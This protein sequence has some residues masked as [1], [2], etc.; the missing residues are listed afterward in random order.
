MPVLASSYDEY[1][2]QD[3]ADKLIL[4]YLTHEYGF[5][6]ASSLDY[7]AQHGTR[8]SEDMTGRYD[9]LYLSGG[10]PYAIVEAKRYS[11]ELRDA[12][13]EQARAY[14]TGP[15]FDRP[16]P[17]LII[18]NGRNHLFYKRTETLDPSDGKLR[19]EQIPPTRWIKITSESPG[20]IR[21]LL[22][23]D[24]LLSIL[25]DVYD[26]TFQDISRLFIDPVTGKY[27]RH[28]NPKLR[29]KEILEE[30]QKFVGELGASEQTHIRHAIRAVSLHFTIKILFIKLIEDLSSGSDTPRIIHTLFPRVEYNLIGGLFGYKVLNALESNDRKTA[31]RIFAKS[32][33]FY[34]LLAQDLA[35][36]SWQ[37]IFRFGFNV[38]SVQYGKLFK[39]HNYD[40]F[41]P[42]ES[43]LANIRARLIMIDIRS[44][45]IY[46]EAAQRV[47]V[48]GQLYERLIDEELRNSIG[49]VYTPDITVRF[50]LDLA[51]R[52]LIRLRGSKILEPS[53]GSGHFYRHIYREYV[54]EV[55]AQNDSLGIARDSHAAHM[56]ALGHIY[57]RDIDPFAI[58]LTLLGVFLEQLKDNVPPATGRGKHPWA[59]NQSV[60]TQNS[61]DPITIDP[62]RYFD[63]QERTLDLSDAK[64]RQR[65]CRR[66]LSPRLIIGNPP[67]GVSVVAGP[68]YDQI[69]KLRSPDSYGYFISNAL[70]RLPEGGR[71]ILI[72]SSSFLTI[73][74]HQELRIEILATAKIIRV[75][76]LSRHMFPGIDIF[77]AIIELERCSDAEERSQN[78]YQFFDLWQVHPEQ[79]ELATAYEAI[80]GDATASAMWPFERTRTARYTVRQGVISTFS[81]LPIFEARV[82]LYEFMR[83]VFPDAP[84]PVVEVVGL[85]GERHQMPAKLVRNRK[86]V[87]LSQL[88]EVKVGLQSGDNPR[89]YRAAPGVRGGAAQGGYQVV[90]FQNVVT[91]SDLQRFTEHEKRN[92]IPVDDPS[93]DRYY[94]PLDK[95]A[96]SDI[97]AGRLPMF[98]RPIEFYI[99]WSESAVRAMR[100]LRGCV[101]R[102]PQFYFQRGVSFS[103]TGIYS[104]TFRLS[105]GGVF[106]QT[107]SCIFSDILSA[108]T[109]LGLLASTLM[110]YFVKSFINHGVHAQLDDLPIALPTS[111]EIDDIE[112][113]IDEIVAE[114]NADPSF[115]YRQKLQELDR[116]VF[117]IYRITTEEQEEVETWYRR[118]YPK[119]F[120]QEAEE[121]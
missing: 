60:D 8:I 73:K 50:M 1:S 100:S 89:F 70:K 78:V 48:I 34:R 102:N 111:E 104:P 12:D 32:K 103:N 91:D 46:G 67:Y 2:E 28:L 55:F 62:D 23:E 41:L 40:R 66:A 25:R 64:S 49:A 65:S 18:S 63:V 9:G 99:D 95:A 112:G 17:F 54:N 117:E 20:E 77:P 93:A 114:Q 22:R 26:K 58:Q 72:V 119:L 7:Q 45:V 74:T 90:N 79:A 116:I 21:R 27:N 14:A 94:V 118:H 69:Y 68:H 53:C 87:K 36:V 83:D 106:D 35:E 52:Y 110:K 81:R 76:K 6:P 92:G 105:H 3:T 16:V 75:I 44:A 5:P 96:V 107:G 84:P 85:D 113:K 11:H 86:V 37:D 57:G 101:F 42:S 82:S 47:N 24:E 51:K 56:E 71:A 121:G 19:Y 33:R 108:K 109:L 43:T 97:E 15:D 120:N 10:F 30:R 13:T 4:P 29:L 80:L 88:A 31:V 61:L 59:A 115:D 39:A 38:H 98:W